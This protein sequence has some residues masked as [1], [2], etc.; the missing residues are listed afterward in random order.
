MKN[1]LAG[2][3]AGAILSA[4]MVGVMF[5][6][7]RGGHSPHGVASLGRSAIVIVLGAV[8]LAAMFVTFSA[9]SGERRR[10]GL[11]RKYS[12]VEKLCSMPWQDFE[13]LVGQALRNKGFK[14]VETGQGGADGGIDLIASRGKY[15]Y[16]IQCKRFLNKKVG[17]PVVREVFGLVGHHQFDGA[18]IF[19]S[20]G[21]TSEAYKFAKDKH[22]ELVDGHK[23][24]EMIEG[25]A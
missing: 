12:T 7:V 5:S 13:L 14:V 20:S 15:R 1:K 11:L 8:A 23:L 4:A 9:L 21:F 24:V 10:K 17:A 2:R 22:I 16:L 19:T 6:L 25:G 18:K 3:L